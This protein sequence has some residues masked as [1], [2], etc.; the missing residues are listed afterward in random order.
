MTAPV[1]AQ[2]AGATAS[3]SVRPGHYS[4]S[5]P[6]SRAYF[7]RAVTPGSS[8]S[9]TVVVANSGRMPLTLLVY[10]VDGLT[11]QTSGSVYANRGVPR[12]KAG[13]WVRVAVS[14]ITVDPG[15]QAT[16]PFVATVPAS[17]TPG[18]RLAGLAVE[19]ADVAMSRGSFRVRQVLREVVGILIT[20]RGPAHPR[21]QLGKL[22][23]Q[24]LPGTSFGTVLV[25]IGNSGRRL[26]K[27]RLVV[28][29]ASTAQHER[30]ARRLDTIL[31]GDTIAYPLV[32]RHDLKAATYDVRARA[33]CAGTTAT[34]SQVIALHS[35]LN[36][37]PTR[38]VAQAAT[39][40][41]VTHSGAPMWLVVG[42]A[43]VAA[44]GGAG[45]GWVLRQRR[46]PV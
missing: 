5:D 41:R 29:L 26:C 37:A 24:T 13:A 43:G 30:I 12:R 7:K 31:P 40:V 38:T 15:A 1:A 6:A 35:Q 36:G 9:D 28:R 21:L 44:V 4:P 19:N 32:L 42:L 20:V 3:F 46:K 39:V 45:I 22:A 34:T 11:G 16:V 14:R 33:S 27:P 2:S 18:D 23:L 17:A 10:P 8:F 25:G